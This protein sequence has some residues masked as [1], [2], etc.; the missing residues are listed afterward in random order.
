MPSPDVRDAIMAATYEALCE[1]GYSDLTAQAI[2]DRTDRSKA[3]LFY[4]YD[5]LEALVADFVEYLLEGF[6]ERL[7]ETRDRPALDRLAAVLDWFLCGP[8]DGQLG[9]HTALLELRA[10][11]PYNDAY[12][13][14]LRESDDRFREAIA[15]I[16]RDGVEEG[17]FREH[18]PDAVAALLLATVDGARIRQFTLGRDE[19]LETVRAETVERVL[20]DVLAPGV[21]FPAEA[22]FEFPRDERLVDADGSP[23]GTGSNRGSDGS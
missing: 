8:E 16:L 3:A 2:A 10:Q 6:D 11:A 21:E 19:Y 9:F 5:S 4:H 12:R 23:A 14:Q 20:A 13:E 17:V 1:V 7:A 18:D 22:P 15:E